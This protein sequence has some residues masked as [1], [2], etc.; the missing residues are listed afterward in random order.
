MSAQLVV[1]CDVCGKE[2]RSSRDAE[3]DW[4]WRSFDVT[5]ITTEKNGIRHCHYACTDT[6]NPSCL[7]LLY[8][9]LGNQVT[10]PGGSE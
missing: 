5:R 4:Y 10:N 1:T 6:K 8:I 3:S 9:K 2:H 7:K